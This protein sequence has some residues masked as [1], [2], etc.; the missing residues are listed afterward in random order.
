MKHDDNIRVLCHRC[1]SDYN[2]AG[3]KTKQISKLREPCDK[4]GC[5]GYTYRIYEIRKRN[6]RDKYDV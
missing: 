5:L 2:T 4:C 1:K 6:K 3:Y